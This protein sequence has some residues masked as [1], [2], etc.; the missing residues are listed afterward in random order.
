MAAARISIGFQL[1]CI[2]Y[3]TEKRSSIYL[4]MKALNSLPPI[5]LGS[6]YWGQSFLYDLSFWRDW[7]E[8]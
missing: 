8:V 3:H 1:D 6:D 4:F 7:G 5:E 2:M